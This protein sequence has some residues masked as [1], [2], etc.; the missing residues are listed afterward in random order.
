MREVVGSSVRPTASVVM[1]NPRRANSPATRARTP[2]LFSTRI[3]RTCLRP[4]RMPPAASR[5]SRLRT[6]D[7]AGSP[8]SL[9]P[10]PNPGN[11]LLAASAHHVSCRLAGGDHR[12]TVLLARDA[13]VDEH[14]APG[15][16]RGLA[17]VG[18]LVPVGHPHADLA[19]R[20]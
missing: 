12:I 19:D 14:R 8:N 4:V 18:E 10:T 11:R 1:L 6:S 20:V 3:E 5:S 16:H 9:L 7:V 13:H 15:L 17:G 2:G